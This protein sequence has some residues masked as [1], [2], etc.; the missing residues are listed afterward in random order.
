MALAGWCDACGSYVPVAAAWRCPHGHDY[1]QVRNHYYVET[2]RPVS[3][4]W[5]PERFTPVAADGYGETPGTREALI[6]ALALAAVAQ[7]GFQAFFGSDCDLEIHMQDLY[8]GRA[9]YYSAQLNVTEADHCMYGKDQVWYTSIPS[10]TMRSAPVGEWWGWPRDTR[11]HGRFRSGSQIDTEATPLWW[12][13]GNTEQI[14]ERVA[15]EHGWRSSW[16][17]R[18]R[19][20]DPSEWHTFG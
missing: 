1:T 14:V 5:L 17:E 20:P 7:P 6:R 2:G 18:K 16:T 15:A 3:A 13:Y 10:F 4:P 8:V 9:G 12:S 11:I 19:R